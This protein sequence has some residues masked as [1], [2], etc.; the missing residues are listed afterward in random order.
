MSE[1]PRFG[2]GTIVRHRDFGRGRVVAYDDDRYVIV[3][4]GGD[5]KTVAFAFDGLEA[6]NGAGDPELDRIVQAV[7]GVLGDHGWLDV[8]LELGKRWVGGTLRLVPAREDGQ[9]KDVPIEAFLKKLV[10]IRDRL[11]VLE[12]KINSHP[13][14]AG[15]E[16]LELQGYITRCYGSLTTFN[17]LFANRASWFVGQAD[18][19]GG[20]GG[21]PPR[22]PPHQ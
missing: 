19:D 6:Q 14:L 13:S 4:P 17:V 8:D 18:K 2:L 15:E 7:R 20:E 9:A 22:V 12:Q 3:F 1:R 11:R 5:A 21:N 10:G 16:K